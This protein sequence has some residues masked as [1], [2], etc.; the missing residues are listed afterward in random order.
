[1]DG[2]LLWTAPE[3]DFLGP[4][5]QAG[6][7]TTRQVNPF[8]DP[9]VDA[10]EAWLP[11]MLFTILFGLSMDYGVFLLSRVREEYVRTGDNDTAVITGLAGTA[12]VI[13]PMAAA[14]AAGNRRPRRKASAASAVRRQAPR[15]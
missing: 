14:S 13:S 11:L 12:R 5:D 6:G 15:L 4:F 2:D 9:L 7:S 8:Q 1:M 3:R 10:I